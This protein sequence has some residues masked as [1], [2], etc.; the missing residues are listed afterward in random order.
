MLTV[1]IRWSNAPIFSNMALTEA[2]SLT[3][4][5]SVRT[6]SPAPS[7]W[8]EDWSLVGLDEQMVTVAFS[9]RHA[10]PTAVRAEVRSEWCA[11]DVTLTQADAARAA[12]D[13]NVFVS[14]RC[15]GEVVPF[16]MSLAYIL[17]RLAVWDDG[18]GSTWK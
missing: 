2:S 16:P 12:D 18:V 3:S 8:T 17:Y 15:H 7:L 5:T 10:C 9:A 4:T 6:A 14:E 13:D 1:Y 11:G